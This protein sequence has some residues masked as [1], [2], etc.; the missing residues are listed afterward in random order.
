M[1][2]IDTSFSNKSVILHS[3]ASIDQSNYKIGKSSLKLTNSGDYA[4]VLRKESGWYFGTGDYT[5]EAWVNFRVTPPDTYSSLFVWGSGGDWFQFFYKHGTGKIGVSTLTNQEPTGRIIGNFTATIGV[6]Y[7]VAVTYRS[8]TNYLFVNGSQINTSSVTTNIPDMTSSLEIGNVTTQRFDGYMDEIRISK[9]IAR[10]TSAFTP[11]T[12]RFVSDQYTTLLLHGDSFQ[13]SSYDNHNINVTGAT[14]NTDPT[15]VK[16]GKGCFDFSGGTKELNIPYKDDF[17]LGARDFAMEGWVYLSEYTSNTTY[18]IIHGYQ[19]EENFWSLA[20]SNSTGYG[21]YFVYSVGSTNIVLLQENAPSAWSVNTWYHVAITRSGN[22]WNLFKNGLRV[23]SASYSG[24][25]SD[26]GISLI[27]GKKGNN[28][29]YFKGNMDGIR[30]TKGIARETSSFTPSLIPFDR[31][32]NFDLSDKTKLL[33]KGIGT[34]GSQTII[35]DSKWSNQIIVYGNTKLD[36]TKGDY[37]IAFDGTNDYINVLNGEA[38]DLDG[39]FCIECDVMFN[40]IGTYQNILSKSYYY[41]GIGWTG[42]ILIL[43]DTNVISFQWNNTNSLA[44]ILDSTTVMVINTWYHISVVRKN[45]VIKLFVNGVAENAIYNNRLFFGSDTLGIG[46]SSNG[47]KGDNYKGAIKFNGYLANIRIVKDDTIYAQNTFGICDSDS[48]SSCKLCLRMDGNAVDSSPSARSG[49]VNSGVTFD[50][51]NKVFGTHSGY[52]NGS[53]INAPASSDWYFNTGD[54]TIEFWVKYNSVSSSGLVTTRNH[55]DS[56]NNFFSLYST[57]S[58]LHF[59][60]NT[61]G[62][63]IINCSASWTPSTGVWYHIAVSRISS[64]LKMFVN[65]TS[66]SYSGSGSGEV[67][68]APSELRIGEAEWYGW[69]TLNGYIDSPKIHKGLGKY[70]ANFNPYMGDGLQYAIS[71]LPML[72]VKDSDTS[73]KLCLRMN[74]NVTDES[75]IGRS[76]TNNGV[77]FDATNKVL[78]SYSGIF[79]GSSSYLSIA[80]SSDFDFGTGDFTIECWAYYK[81]PLSSESNI[82]C[83][84]SSSGNGVQIFYYNGTVLNVWNNETVLTATVSIQTNVWNHLAVSRSNGNCKLFLNGM[85]ITTSIYSGSFIIPAHAHGIT[86]GCECTAPSQF[87]YGLIDEFKVYKGFAKY[88][89]NFNPLGERVKSLLFNGSES[90]IDGAILNNSNTKLLLHLNNDFRDY[91]A[92]AS[93]VNTPTIT[94]SPSISKTV[95]RITDGSCY[96]NGTTDYIS[97]ANSSD[98]DFGSGDLT[99]EFWIKTTQTSSGVIFSKRI[100]DQNI[101]NVYVSLYSGKIYVNMAKVGSSD[102]ELSINSGN[103][104]AD[105]IWHHCAVVRVGTS[106]VLYVDGVN[107]SSS[108]LT[109]LLFV[110]TSSVIIGYN[111]TDV[112]QD[113]YFN[114]YLQELIVTKGAAKYTSNFTPSTI[115]IISSTS[116]VIVN[117]ISDKLVACYKFEDNQLVVDSGPSKYDLT[118]YGVTL[119]SGKFGKCAVFNGSAYLGG[120]ATGNVRVTLTPVNNYFA[121]SLWTYPTQYSAYHMMFTFNDGIHHCTSLYSDNTQSDKLILDVSDSSF[122]A[123][124]TKTDSSLSLNTWHHIFICI[125]KTAGIWLY[126]DGIKYKTS[127]SVSNIASNTYFNIGCAGGQAHKYYGSIDELYIWNDSSALFQNENQLD[128]FAVALYNSGNGKFING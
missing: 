65:G 36:S 38:F 78:G 84:A 18:Y 74:N 122:T 27:I 69:R 110:N 90:V 24:T 42:W 29:N 73:C 121:A 23:S 112:G 34:N 16:I 55:S 56:G 58:V 31:R 32:E 20:V 9:G 94:G 115:P 41:N 59:V 39:D 82:I 83:W 127:I 63:T 124:Q 22:T 102:W 113:S 93:Q 7:H 17:N 51:A 70:S 40:S 45:G 19:D 111:D 33:I 79:N 89:S 66:L 119:G 98:F 12:T 37:A 109:G 75:P 64:V 1:A 114:G 21:L 77:T 85:I 3:G 96:F 125:D 100:N 120:N 86:I 128:V 11:Q 126:V 68:N 26:Y 88:T 53:N 35:D 15:I 76:V 107:K 92:G 116:N 117:S 44:E 54:F 14:I 118:N 10:Y 25:I 43:K 104:I 50:N 101:C 72:N 48:L 97:I 95:Y 28:V 61:N 80:N 87:L 91:S 57:S 106:V 123:Y 6:W 67:A 62:D 30:L 52:F 99:I 81:T 8:G 60:G 4:E 46:A 2:A 13:D 47:T 105:D 5:V 108:S 103:S 49:I 71:P